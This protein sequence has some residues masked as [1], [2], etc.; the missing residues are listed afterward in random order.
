MECILEIVSNIII[1]YGFPIFI[2]SNTSWLGQQ[3]IFEIVT[4]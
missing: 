2:F 1:S 3:K 4:K